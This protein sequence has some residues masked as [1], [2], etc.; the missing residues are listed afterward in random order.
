MVE[1][2]GGGRE[3]ERER[4]RECEREREG[5]P[6][7][8]IKSLHITA[9]WDQFWYLAHNTKQRA[10]GLSKTGC[11]M[12]P[13]LCYLPPFFTQLISDHWHIMVMVGCL[14]WLNAELSLKRHWQGPRSQEVGEKEDYTYCYTVTSRMTPTLRLAAMTAMSMFH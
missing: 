13:L 8:F 12:G 4:E 5:S 1:W 9:P 11:R 7:P 10:L 14:N 3:R 6:T 2:R